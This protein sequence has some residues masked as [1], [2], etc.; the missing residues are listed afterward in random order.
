VAA[1]MRTLPTNRGLTKDN[2]RTA[3]KGLT[4]NAYGSVLTWAQAMR[5]APAKVLLLALDSCSSVDVTASPQE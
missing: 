1:A 2:S 3:D 4:M 5:R